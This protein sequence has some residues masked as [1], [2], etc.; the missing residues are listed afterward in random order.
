MSISLEQ[1][2]FLER[3]RRSPFGA[4][5][6]H[7]HRDSIVH[8]I[9]RA[10]KGIRPEF[11][12]KDRS[13]LI[14]RFQNEA[15]TLVSVEAAEGKVLLD[16]DCGRDECHHR[17]AAF[18]L[19]KKIADP[20]G[21]STLALPETDL[22]LLRGRLERGSE[23][24]QGRFA[25]E[26]DGEDGFP[27]IRVTDRG[28]PVRPYS[29]VPSSLVRLAFTP[30]WAEAKSVQL[31]ELLRRKGDSWP[32]FFRKG[33]RLHP[34][35]WSCESP[36]GRLWLN[37]EEDRLT[38]REMVGERPAGPEDFSFGPFLIDLREGRLC[39]AE[40]LS[41]WRF[42]DSLKVSA[43]ESAG[44]AIDPQARHF[45]VSSKF[46]QQFHF[47]I[48]EEALPSFQKAVR[49]ARN[50]ADAEPERGE[51][52]QMRLRVEMVEMGCRLQAEGYAGGQG[53]GVD[54]ELFALFAEG[55]YRNLS[56]P[57]RTFKRRPALIDAFF[58]CAVQ[59]SKSR[60]QTVFRQA[61]AGSD[62]VK[63]II[64]RE[65]KE[66][67][68]TLLEA[69]EHPVFVLAL[70]QGEW[71]LLPR[72]R[73]GEMRLMKILFDL[74]GEKPFR[75]AEKPG[76]AQVGQKAFMEKFG[77]LA[78]ALQKGGGELL[79][80]G[81]P[82]RSA[83][84]EYEV[85]AV[86]S[87]IDWFEIRPEIRCDGVVL[88]Q[89]E[90]LRALSSGLLPMDGSLRILDAETLQLIAE[91]ARMVPAADSGRRKGGEQIVRIPRLHI[92]DV[93]SLRRRGVR[94]RLPREDEEILESLLAFETLPERPLPQNLHCTMRPYQHR[95]YDWFSFLYTHKF[96]A[97][98]ADDMGL[99]KTVQAISLLAAL[100]DGTLPSRITEPRPHLIVVPPSLLFNWEAEIERFCPDL[101]TL[102]YRGK[103]RS[104]DF[105]E[106][107]IVLT[108]YD[109]VRRDAARL[110]GIPFHVIVF[111][112]AQAVKNP[113]A[114]VTGAAR[115][116]RGAFKIALTGTP[117]ENRLEDYWSVLDLAVPGLLG[118]HRSFTR[119]E[120]GEGEAQRIERI[121]RRTRPFV[122]RRSKAMIADELPPRTESDLYLELTAEQRA[123]Y[124]RT[125]EAARRTVNEAYSTR[126]AAQA[127]I[128]A[129]A[130]LMKLRRICLS[131]RLEGGKGKETDPKV[132]ALIEH[133]EE[134]R[135]E[136]HSAL[137]FSQFT[138]FLDLVEPELA[139]RGFS[140]YRLD[141][142]TPVGARKG[143]VTKFQRSEEPAVFLLSLKAGGR[144]LNLTRATYVF[145]L[146]PWWNPAVENQASDRA[147]RI[148][149][150]DKVTVV[151]LLMRHTVEEKMMVLKEKKLK[152]YQALL[153]GEMGE[154]AAISREEIA[155]LLE[156]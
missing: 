39:L 99:G 134:L 64:R 94:V 70:H 154:D 118:D 2:H 104:T 133:L 137:V 126:T 109:L 63:R 65:A 46:L 151:R 58:R 15:E 130:A 106:A 35:R 55:F 79:I 69:A 81:R 34:L 23:V 25:I 26:L 53:F 136:G 52:L 49:L 101:K 75:G 121:V 110:T 57:L 103:E 90:W 27:R 77:Q 66:L 74:F 68:E 18:A 149:Q 112:E 119:G 36:T 114:A 21:F 41:G 38:V 8:G 102:I 155:Y 146:D 116:L 43:M 120:K 85:E 97:C 113:K 67:I 144:G 11:F 143:L 150:T 115:R 12:W 139:R 76:S 48:S 50:G 29:V 78:E 93:L 32:V 95:G 61:L 3:I 135:D 127:R 5:Y 148:G 105:A 4:L 33:S 42:F 89:E 122:L 45:S 138:S 153:G 147:H 9:F 88:T 37:A 44:A 145:H 107:D 108:S 87:G 86:P 13:T 140:H 51:R 124:T 117:V 24:D 22:T 142:S 92:F 132:E 152:L 141:G 98:L 111:D 125:A 1:N 62:F 73:E 80:D 96:G 40:D 83:S 131:P 6:A 60:R 7:F 56:L 20:G 47:D 84:L 71:R 28:E 31:V 156:G 123:L 59:D 91:M 82:V 19:I 72:D 54:P 100:K 30:E 16:C 129:L 17:V 128:T 14:V 10:Q